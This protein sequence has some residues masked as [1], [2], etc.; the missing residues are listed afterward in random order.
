[1][2][3]GAQLVVRDGQK[4]GVGQEDPGTALVPLV[5]KNWG[6]REDVRSRSLSLNVYTAMNDLPGGAPLE[7]TPH[8][9][10]VTRVRWNLAPQALATHKTPGLRIE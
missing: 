9:I 5:Y 2:P 3:Y 10:S 6:N 4:V 7:V 1:M 8:L